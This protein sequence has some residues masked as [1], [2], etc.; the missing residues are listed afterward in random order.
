MIFRRPPTGEIQTVKDGNTALATRRELPR[1]VTMERISTELQKH[2][3]A[4]TIDDDGDLTGV[5]DNHQ[6]WFILGGNEKEV[7]QVRGRWN[8]SLGSSERLSALLAVN[9]WNR[10]HI[11]PKVYVRDEVDLVIYAEVSI[12]FEYGVTD[13]QLR[14]V[15]ACG[16]VTAVQF[17]NNFGTT[18]TATLGLES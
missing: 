16:L 15:I 12:D 10:D 11:W 14:E 6:F 18:L 3:Y 8:S 1:P 7:L 17:F 4:F 13:A 2:N 5:W 9:D